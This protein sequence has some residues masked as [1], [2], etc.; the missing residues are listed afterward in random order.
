MPI[1][2]SRNTLPHGVWYSWN[3]PFTLHVKRHSGVFIRQG[4]NLPL[5]YLYVYPTD[6][7]KILNRSKDFLGHASRPSPFSLEK[8]PWCPF[9]RK[10]CCFGAAPEIRKICSKEKKKDLSL[11]HFIAQVLF[12]MWYYRSHLVKLRHYKLQIQI[13]A[14][15]CGLF[16]DLFFFNLLLLE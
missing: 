9:T 5:V 16:T 8:C 13:P 1:S 15:H 12:R 10:L 6:L 3:F 11:V 7:I 14:A 4:V 2:S